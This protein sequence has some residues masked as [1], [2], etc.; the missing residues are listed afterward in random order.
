[1][2]AILCSRWPHRRIV[3]AE[4]ERALIGTIVEGTVQGVHLP[5]CVYVDIGLSCPAYIDAFYL[6]DR[7][8]AVGDRI[9]VRPIGFEPIR[10]GRFLL[11]PPHMTS[12]AE[13]FG[14]TTVDTTVAE[15]PPGRD[16]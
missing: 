3:R 5:H 14:W 8:Y 15:D 4:S 12:A 11:R 10:G 6:D 9:E 16:R 2:L 7:Q 1:M 13:K